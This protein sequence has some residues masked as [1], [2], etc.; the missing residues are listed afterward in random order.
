MVLWTKAGTA[1]VEGNV[2]AGRCFKGRANGIYCQIECGVS[3]GKGKQEWA[4]EFWPEPG[5]GRSCHSPLRCRTGLRA[6]VRSSVLSVDKEHLRFGGDVYT[7]YTTMGLSVNR[8]YWKPWDDWDHQGKTCRVWAT[9]HSEGQR[10][11]REGANRGGWE[12]AAREAGRESGRC[13]VREAKEKAFQGFAES[14]IVSDAAR[15]PS[16]N[17]RVRFS[18]VFLYVSHYVSEVSTAAPSMRLKYNAC[19]RLVQGKT[20]HLDFFWTGY[21]L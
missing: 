21:M 14:S 12:K 15:R 19:Y 17:S 1:E 6:S 8:W 10:V 20:G 3:E 5:G 9:G 16:S 18:I 7:R 13:G 2:G 4:P 11:R